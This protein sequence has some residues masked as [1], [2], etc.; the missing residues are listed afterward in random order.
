MKKNK[1]PIIIALTV[2][3]IILLPLVPILINFIFHLGVYLGNFLR[4][5]YNFVVI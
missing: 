5:L 2:L 4:N 1:M 3:V